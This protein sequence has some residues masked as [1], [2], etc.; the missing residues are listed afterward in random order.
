MF[1]RKMGDRTHW[2]P[3]FQ[4]FIVHCT[5]FAIVSIVENTVCVI[6]SPNI[7]V[8]LRNSLAKELLKEMSYP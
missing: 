4:I 8:N 1:R 5:S 2:L 7:Y 6:T 3:F